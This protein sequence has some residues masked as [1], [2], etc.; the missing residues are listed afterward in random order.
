[1]KKILVI[2]TGGTICSQENENG[3]RSAD[4]QNAKFRIVSDFR[5]SSSPYKDTDFDF[6]MPLNILSENMTIATWNTLLDTFRENN[7]DDYKGIIILHGGLKK[8]LDI[9]SHPSEWLSSKRPQ[10]QMLVR[11]WRRRNS[12]TL[13]VGM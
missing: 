9:T 4:A 11:I 3:E 7:F 2:L 6:T 5:K 1:M 13:L 8:C 10:K 12:R